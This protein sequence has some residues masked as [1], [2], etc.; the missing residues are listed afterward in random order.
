MKKITVLLAF[1]II[2]NFTFGITSIDAQEYEDRN[3][4][5]TY[6]AIASNKKTKECDD[7]RSF[8]LKEKK[9]IIDSL[10]ELIDNMKSDNE[11]IGSKLSEVNATLLALDEQL[12]IL[13]KQIDELKEEIGRLERE[14]E[15]NQI[16]VDDLEQRTL[17]R[18]RDAQETMHFNAYLDF[19]LGSSSFEDLMRRSYGVEAINSKDE[20]D[21]K[22]LEDAINKL[23]EDKDELDR[24]KQE[25]DYKQGEVENEEAYYLELKAEY[26]RAVAR[27]NEIIEE[28]MNELDDA[29]SDYSNIISEIGDIS[30]IPSSSG[31]Y[32]PAPG[33]SI[34]AGTWYYPSGGVHLGVDYGLSFGSNIYAPA[35]GVVTLSADGCPSTGYLGNGC[36]ANIGGVYA[37]GNQVIMIVSADNVVYG[38]SFFHLQQG[39]PVGTGFISEGDYVGRV[40]SSG[41]SS[42]PHCH[43]ELYYLG[44]GDMEDIQNDY[45]LR[46]Y[47]LS[48]GCG[49]GS[50]GLNKLCENGAKAPCRLRPELYFGK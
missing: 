32:S 46:N 35:N 38:V 44:P 25:L 16:L 49:W 9:E 18:M 37:G 19:I 45:L 26:D 48:F 31:L 17:Q 21:R 34:N 23:R 39:S 11:V 14:I 13:K 40:G 27:N 3:Y 2:L 29:L 42:G 5:D 12:E 36:G 43:I 22:K 15:A 33:A 6:C 41:N 4:W 8:L 20:E 10:K 50:A 28:K 1:C 7:Y 24:A 47:S 30:N